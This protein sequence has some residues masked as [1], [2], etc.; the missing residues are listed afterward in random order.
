LNSLFQPK[1]QRPKTALTTAKQVNKNA[2]F[3]RKTLLNHA[4]QQSSQRD[5]RNNLNK[6]FRALSKGNASIHSGYKSS[7][8]Q[9]TY[10]DEIDQP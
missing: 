7:Y 6:S 1:G 5:L 4:H 3:Y 8:Q 10:I 2:S 9:Q